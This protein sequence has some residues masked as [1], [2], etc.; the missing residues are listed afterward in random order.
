MWRNTL[1][2]PEIDPGH[3]RTHSAD[4]KTTR[5]TS[6]HT[7]LTRNCP[8]TWQNTLCRPEIDPGH[9]GTHS[10]Y[11]T[12]FGKNGKNGREW[13]EMAGKWPGMARN[14]WEWTGMARNG[15]EWPGMTGNDRKM[16]GNGQGMAREW[17]GMAR[18]DWEWT[19]MAGNG[20]K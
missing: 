11:V 5:D 1:C 13:L 4:R 20:R 12:H 10:A 15:R 16:D 2:R 6:K 3:G 7:L 8:G 19:G 17:P 9:G 14:D 18:N